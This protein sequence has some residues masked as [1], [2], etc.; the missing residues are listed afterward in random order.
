M[1]QPANTTYIGQPVRRKEDLRLITG[2][3]RFSDDVNLP[4]QVY[5]AMLRSPHAHARVRGID[6]RKAL[7][8]PGVIAV[9][10][11]ADFI[12][13]G[14][15][16]IPYNQFTLH[17]AEQ[18]LP[19]SDGTPAFTAPCYSIVVDKARYVGEVVAIVIANTFDLAKDG[20]EAIVVDYEVLPAVTATIAAA[21]PLA[22]RLWDEAKSN[23]CV[24]A[25]VGAKDATAAAFARAAHVAKLTTW[26]QRV[27]GVPMEPRAAVGEYD[28]AT[29]RYTLHAGSGGSV[30][31]KKDLALIFGIAED[32]VRVLM[33]DVGGN[34]GPA[35]CP[36]RSGSTSGRAA[37]TAI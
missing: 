14:M 11:G 6:S 1:Y 21:E 13:D 5:A 3:G 4:N 22:P 16:P 36:G 24:D 8:I 19:N 10:T 30:R 32:Q 12:A 33:D 37:S 25:D 15:Q 9:F 18:Q 17:P 23:V 31:L 20:A 35:P 28:A 34:F 7:A 27:T 26:I 2:K 29:Q